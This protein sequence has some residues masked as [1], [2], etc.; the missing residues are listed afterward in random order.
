MSDLK[1]TGRCLCGEVEF[2]VTLQE[3]DVHVCHCSIC[4]KW[5]G[6][7]SLSLGCESG[8]KIKGEDNLTWFASSE[9]AERGFC[10]KCGSHLFFRMNDGRYQGIPAAALDSQDG[11]KIASHIF[12]DKKPPYYDFADDTPR[13]TEEEFLKMVGAAE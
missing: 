9:W 7:P 2:E 13:L 5:E 8:W 6:G 4:Q 12:I 3:L 11:L 1:R 10:K